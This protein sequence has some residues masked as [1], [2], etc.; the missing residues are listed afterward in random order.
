MPSRVLLLTI[1]LVFLT[2]GA[3]V[4]QSSTQWST[5]APGHRSLAVQL[6][7]FDAGSAPVALPPAK[8]KS[9]TTAGFLSA[10]CL[11]PPVCGLGS[12]YAGHAGHGW[13]HL[14]IGVASL[15]AAFAASAA[16]ECSWG[17]CEP[18]GAGKAV[19]IVGLLAY[20]GNTIWS[21]AVA[22]DDTWR[23][24]RSLDQSPAQ[25]AV[26]IEVL[27]PRGLPSRVSA[28]VSRP[29]LAVRFVW[30]SF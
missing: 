20:Y 15:G 22:V 28:S 12:F 1:L 11:L 13:R 14:S 5:A 21:T 16:G 17:I 30:V 23:H 9:V 29:A 6:P 19:F 26:G 2:S 3:V 24:N 7:P 10:A 25:L 4:A 18:Q 8:A 27:P